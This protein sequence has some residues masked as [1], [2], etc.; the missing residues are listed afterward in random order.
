MENKRVVVLVTM[1][2]MMLMGN[3]LAQTDAQSSS[4]EKCFPGCFVACLVENISLKK[5]EAALMCPLKCAKSCFPL[6]SGPSPIASPPSE[7]I[8]TNE[9]D[10]IDYFCQLDC[11]T[12]LCAPLSS[13]RNPIYK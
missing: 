13:L 8:S 9:I 10:H 6:P 1:M 11:A 7:M 5:S 4:F 12:R 3:L 2:I